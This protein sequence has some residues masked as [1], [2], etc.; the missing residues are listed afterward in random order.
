MSDQINPPHYR[1]CKE[2]LGVEVIDILEF[3]FPNDP[4]MWN[5]G[6]Y[7]LRGG[8]KDGAPMVIERGKAIWYLERAQQRDAAFRADERAAK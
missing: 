4:L 2:V 5:A 8:H 1:R 3:F 7:L 6:K